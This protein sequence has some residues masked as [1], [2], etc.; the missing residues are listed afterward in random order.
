MAKDGGKTKDRGKGR[1]KDG[2]KKS[3]RAA[4]AATT[5]ATVASSMGAA[6]LGPIA[7]RPALPKSREE[8]LELWL[9]ARRRRHAAPLDSKAY[10]QA[11]EDVARIEVEIAAVERALTPPLV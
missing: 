8:L 4:K 11:S 5:E 1:A 10:V 6:S 2:S 7:D 3:P 9:E